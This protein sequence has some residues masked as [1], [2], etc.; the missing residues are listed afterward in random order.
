MGHWRA[1]AGDPLS[2][3][4]GAHAPLRASGT[5]IPTEL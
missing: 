3:F 4:N 2:L 5:L 1:Q